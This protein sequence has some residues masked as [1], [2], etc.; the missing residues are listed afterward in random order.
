MD[1]RNISS[2]KSSYD[3]T[4]VPSH[5]CP[6]IKVAN[7]FGRFLTGTYWHIDKFALKS[8]GNNEK[9]IKN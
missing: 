8:V 7:S 1:A 2:G 5:A 9:L 4:K 6:Y 3:E